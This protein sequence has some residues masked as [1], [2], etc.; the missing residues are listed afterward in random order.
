M[1]GPKYWLTALVFEVGDMLDRAGA[2][3]VVTSI[4]APAGHRSRSEDGDERHT[5]IT[6]RPARD[7]DGAASAES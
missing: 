5:T 2:S 6:V 7:G 1:G 4:S 3:W